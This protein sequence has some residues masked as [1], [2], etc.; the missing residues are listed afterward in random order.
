MDDLD[1]FVVKRTK[2]NPRFPEMVRRRRGMTRRQIG[3][4]AKD[5]NAKLRADDPRFRGAVHL[6]HEEGTAFFLMYAFIVQVD[7]WFVVFTEHH[8]HMVYGTDEIEY[9]ILTP[10]FGPAKRLRP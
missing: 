2:D 5:Y 10:T 4:W 9:T 3:K 1:D 8:G 6:A 7:E